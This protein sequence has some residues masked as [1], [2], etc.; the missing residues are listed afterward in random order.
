MGSVAFKRDI[1]VESEHAEERTYRRGEFDMRMV[2]NRSH[3]HMR[4]MD[5]RSGNYEQKCALLDAMAREEGLRK[6]FTVVEKQDSNSWRSAGF[7]R[8]AVFPSFFRTAD[9]YMMS[10]IYGPD[11]QPEQVSALK[12][13]TDEQTKFPGRKLRKPDALTLDSVTSERERGEIQEQGGL[14]LRTLP[15]SRVRPPELAVRGRARKVKPTF[16]C[17]EVDDSFAHAMIGF[18]PVPDSEPSMVLCAYAGNLLISQ[19]LEREIATVFAVSPLDDRWSNELLSGL[20]FKVTGRLLS[21]L[22][23]DD[24]R[25]GG[26]PEFTNA[27]L[28]HRRIAP[29]KQ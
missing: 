20:G 2:I 22:R 1:V 5:Y 18:S 8:E 9:A 23:V 3:L 10:R 29:K 13:S 21:H 15:F 7:V 6:V 27:L 16:V 25:D 19:V 24:P 12:S 14:A 26:A 28:W 11:G 4:I 17:A